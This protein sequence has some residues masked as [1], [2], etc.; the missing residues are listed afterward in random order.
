MKTILTMIAAVA[1][2][3]G[4]AD[5]I[6]HDD[7]APLRPSGNE[8]TYW[9]TSQ[10]S[11]VTLNATSISLGAAR[12]SDSV[13]AP[14]ASTLTNVEVRSVAYDVTEGRNVSTAPIGA[15]VILR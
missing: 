15:M 3:A 9:K 7:L 2:F 11:T 8:N 5:T 12:A 13:S 14:S 6:V 4:L 10:R 1:V